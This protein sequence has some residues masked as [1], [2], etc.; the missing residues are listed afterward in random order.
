MKQF[1]H[2]LIIV[3]FTSLAVLVSCSD[4]KGKQ[5]DQKKEEAST[6]ATLTEK[7]IDTTSEDKLLF[8]VFN[9]LSQ[10][11]AGEYEDE[12]KKVMSWNASQQAIYM[13]WLLES[14]VNNGG[15]NQFY[16]NSS[17]Q[18]YKL[19]PDALK[20]IGANKFA[21]LTE[22]ANKIYEQEKDKITKHQDGSVEGFSKSYDNNPLNKLDD[23]FYNLYK[24]EDLEKL[25]IDYIRSH[26]Q[27]F[28]DK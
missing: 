1:L 10:K 16:Y 13:I 2:N 20:L 5:I 11:Q 15:Y 3:I 27:D 23:E 28:I 12:F 22:R 4:E 25:Q 21:D 24:K 7:A 8:L 6:Y 18:F 19:L 14:E 9:V 17:G 26:K